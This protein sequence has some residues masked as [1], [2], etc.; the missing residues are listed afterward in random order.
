MPKRYSKRR[1]NR[2]YRRGRKHNRGKTTTNVNR[3]LQPFPNRYICKMKYATTVS[4]DATGQY[5]FRLNSL[6]DPDL[7]GVGHQPYGFDTASGMYNRYRVIACGWR[8]Q[9][10]SA[11]NG[12]PTILASLPNNDALIA[13]SNFGEMCENP[14]AKWV[15]NN[16]GATSP[17]LKGKVYLPKL[18]G[19]SRT[20]YMA[21]DNYQAIVTTNPVENGFLYVTSFNATTGIASP[22]IPMNVILEFTIEFFD[23]KHQ[24]QS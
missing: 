21:D 14:R 11:Y 3:S 13:W 19:R 2:R 7:T 18:M 22:G 15:T 17:V 24:L 10:P 16:P 20:Q 9:Q 12:T 5:Q 6:F 23:L 1:S 4:T 8:I